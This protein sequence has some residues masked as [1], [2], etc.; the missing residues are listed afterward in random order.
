[1]TKKERKP[2]LEE[3]SPRIEELFREMW[4]AS[5]GIMRGISVHYMTDEDYAPQVKSDKKE[6]VIKIW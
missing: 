5:G 2:L 6:F 3:F 1:M 4:E